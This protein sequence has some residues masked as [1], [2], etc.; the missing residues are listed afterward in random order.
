MFNPYPNLYGNFPNRTFA[1]IFPDLE[2]FTGMYKGSGLYIE[3]NKLDDNSISIIYYLLYARYGNS[4][5][6]SYDE[7]QFMYKVF[8]TIFMY[9][10]TWEKR[11]EIQGK[12][13]TL[14]EN[15]L[16]V[17]SKRINNKSLNPSIAPT[18]NTLDELTTINEQI[19]DGWKKSKLEGYANLMALVDTDVTEEF[20]GKFKKLFI[21]VVEPNLPLWYKTEEGALE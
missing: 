16:I 9:G 5:I 18:T 8:S 10:P 21:V 14:T 17:G 2:V 4:V 13:R 19:T 20:I 3:P 11:L 7:N 6:A 12:L 1:N 15:E